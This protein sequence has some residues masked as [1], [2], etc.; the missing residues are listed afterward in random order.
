MLVPLDYKLATSLINIYFLKFL[1][2][3]GWY[4]P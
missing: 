4:M 2:Q 3:K 1:L